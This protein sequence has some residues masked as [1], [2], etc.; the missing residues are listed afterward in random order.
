MLMDI[1]I[2]ILYYVTKHIGKSA[3]NREYNPCRIPQEV[4]GEQN[5]YQTD[6]RPG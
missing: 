1:N 5:E 2:K 6:N 4:L 3:V